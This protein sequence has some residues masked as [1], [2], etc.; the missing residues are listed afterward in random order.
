MPNTGTLKSTIL[1]TGL[2]LSV[3]ADIAKHILKTRGF[4]GLMIGYA[5]MQAHTLNLTCCR[6]VKIATQMLAM[7]G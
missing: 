3:Q 4:N 6:G 5:G 1:D 2:A 7:I